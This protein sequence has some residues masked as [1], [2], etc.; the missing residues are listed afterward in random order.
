MIVT[1]RDAFVE[2][3]ECDTQWGRGIIII[4]RGLL[5]G[6]RIL[7]VLPNAMRTA[8]FVNLVDTSQKD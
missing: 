7:D 1:R 2:T 8:L 6:T 3:T 5:K 4:I